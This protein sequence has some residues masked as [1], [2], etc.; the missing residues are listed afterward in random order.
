M[1]RGNKTKRGSTEGVAKGYRLQPETHKLVA[2]LQK[3]IKGTKN[4]VISRACGMLNEEIRRTK[5]TIKYK[6]KN[7]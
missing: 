3:E 1:S 5:E 4:D 7:N 6:S 2:K